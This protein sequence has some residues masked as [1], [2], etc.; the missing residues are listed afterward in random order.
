VKQ[1][2]RNNHDPVEGTGGVD[3]HYHYDG[4]LDNIRGSADGVPI[5]HR[6]Q[7][8]IGRL[9]YDPILGI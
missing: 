4:P 3:R 8:Y 1:N 2:G 5:R 6:A 7:S 9:F